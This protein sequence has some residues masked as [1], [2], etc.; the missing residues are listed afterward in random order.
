V[1][2]I[3]PPPP[4]QQPVNVGISAIFRNATSTLLEVGEPRVCRS[5]SHECACAVVEVLVL[6]G[7][8]C[9]TVSVCVLLCV[10]QRVCV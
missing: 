10:R 1:A 7:L 9:A 3:P 6:C 2:A 4:Q 8:R 5:A